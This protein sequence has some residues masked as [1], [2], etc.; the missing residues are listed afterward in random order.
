MQS[1]PRTRS[2]LRRHFPSF[3]ATCLAAVAALGAGSATAESKPA[4]PSLAATT[5]RA[6]AK[7]V[8][9]GDLARRIDAEIGRL[10]AA[11]QPGAAVLVMKD[12][13]PILR[14]GYGLAS[15]E[16]NVPIAPEMVF[17]LGS[18]TK[19]FT[20]VAI[21]MLV[22]QGKLTLDTPLCAVLPECPAVAKDKVT[23]R[24]LLTHTSGLA[25]YTD[26]PAF[27]EAMR[28]DHRPADILA[29]TAEDP[30][31]FAP[32]ERFAYNNT[33]YILLG[34]V[35]EKIT[36]KPYATVIQER[37]FDQVGMRHSYYD[38]ADLLIPGRVAGYEPTAKG[39]R[40]APYLSMSA[41]YAAGSLASS[42][43]DLALW[44]AALY[45]E[46]LL[47]QATLDQ[48]WTA[49]PVSGPEP[50]TYGFG[51]VVGDYKGRR[52][53]LHGGG[54]QGFTTSMLRFPAEKLLVVVLS[55]GNRRS[56]DVVAQRAAMMALGD[57][58]R[59]EPIE[60]P[61]EKLSRFEGVYKINDT[62]RRVVRVQDGKLT[63]QRTGGQ[64]F[65]LLPLGDAEFLFADEND[66]VTFEL[67]AQGKPAA[68]LIHRWG[69]APERTEA[70]DE[71]LP[72]SRQ[73]IQLTP[74]ELDRVVGDYELQPGFVL[75]VRREGVKLTA[76]ATGQSALELFAESPTKFFLKAVDA[77]IAFVIDG[78]RASAATLLQNGGI[79]IG[80]RLP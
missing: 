76:Q 41:P 72:A 56:P 22:E 38:M 54:I 45:G 26:K 8:L 16:L 80:K 68:M 25:S 5:E 66:R 27:W 40:P 63:S 15:L 43:D 48:A 74:A 2:G 44:D 69:M 20:A 13:Q 6:P 64:L 55:N 62:V 47:K 75:S 39:Y 21:L 51:W 49:Y 52:V 3:F 9:A 30:L 35:I 50:S 1:I 19:Q 10:Y 78:E 28:R 34:M 79:L 24:H 71:P 7:E 23:I 31:Q 65:T 70:T 29:Y 37:I 57:M 60:M 77:Q 4:R 14:K 18:I 73:E 11:D 67:D 61:A 32:G 33:G 53:I 36:G 42:V 17:R 46:Q 12:G 58:Q 59:F